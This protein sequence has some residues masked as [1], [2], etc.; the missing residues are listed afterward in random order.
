MPD[1]LKDICW[2]ENE[3]RCESGE[4]ECVGIPR[5]RYMEDPIVFF[6][7][8]MAGESPVR[9]LESPPSPSRPL[10]LWK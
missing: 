1:G 5:F 8:K 7:L 4:I 3:K 10:N 9:R 6:S 2:N